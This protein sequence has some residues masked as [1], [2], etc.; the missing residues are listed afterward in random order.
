VSKNV[1]SLEFY[2]D[3]AKNIND[4]KAVKFSNDNTKFDIALI[5]KFSDK[6]E[7]LLDI[8]S[9]TGLIVNNL[10]SDF[11]NIV[12]I[13][14]FQEFSSYITGSNISVV[15]ENILDFSL[16]R[17]FYT[18]TMFG[19]AHYF[20]EGESLQIFKK[21]FSMVADDGVFIL[22]NQFGVKGT[23]TVTKSQEL[24]A[25]YFAQYRFLEY[26]IE[27]LKSIGFSNIEVNDIYPVEANKWDDTHFY[28]L[29]CKKT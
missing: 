5:R 21:I 8:G 12:A 10:T 13:E 6:Q 14:L 22:K 3:L 23:K 4:P 1:Q 11:R 7:D 29:I 9:G 18:V 16:D 15:N 25:K 28:A 27:R 26:E 24:G 2:Q 20:D 19:T 17:T